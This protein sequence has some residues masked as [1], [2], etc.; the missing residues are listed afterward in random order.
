[1]MGIPPSE[2]RQLSWW[3]YQAILW[4]WNDRHDTGDNKDPVEPP[5]DESVLALSHHAEVRGLARMIH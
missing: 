2:A 5:S 1:M 4:N 3:E